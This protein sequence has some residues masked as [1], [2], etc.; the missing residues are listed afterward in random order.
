LFL[1]AKQKMGLYR[2]PFEQTSLATGG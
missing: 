2:D 1:L